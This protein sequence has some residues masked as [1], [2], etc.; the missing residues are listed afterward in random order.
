M[1]QGETFWNPYR[2]I[3][4]REE[5]R[6][7]PPRTH[8]RVSGNSG[9]LSCTLVN[10]TPLF[11]GGHGAGNFHP[12]MLRQNKRV[13]PGASLKGMLRS[14]VE[15]VG[16]G[17]FVVQNER[18][19]HDA[20]HDSCEKT[21]ELCVGCRMFGM[22]GKQ[23]HM[24]N[25][26]IGDALIREERAE[27]IPLEVLLANNK[28]RHEP[29]YRNPN[30]SRLDGNNRKLYFHQPKRKESTPPIPA[31]ISD[32]AWRIDA[33]KPG[34]HFDF[35]IQFVNLAEDEL[36]LLVYALALEENVEVAVGKG[37]DRVR[38]SGP[39]R[40]KIGNAKPAGLGSSHI[41]IRKMVRLPEPGKRFASLSGG[42]MGA[43][44]EGKA[45]RD[46]IGKRT[47][48]WRDD[49]SPTMTALRKMM[50]WDESD[51]RDFRY[52]DYTWFKNSQ[53]SGTPLKPI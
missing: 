47:A 1:P 45:L 12:P 24:G 50:V 22:I 16:G 17:C 37:E 19:P 51:P 6:R 13:I 33:V 53:N 52:P 9:V 46:E 18:M 36:D 32:K 2:L 7:R 27:T 38:L 40:H 44:L 11:I 10:L 41:E 39:L 4:I 23:V 30:S 20:K 25:V 28:L 48:K 14:L 3:P 49:T 31:S 35:E 42:T 21:D 34:H 43:T 15:I 5:I 26:R 29:F 8:E